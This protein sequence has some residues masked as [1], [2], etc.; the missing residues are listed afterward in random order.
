MR[1][2]LMSNNNLGFTGSAMYDCDFCHDSFHLLLPCPL[3]VILGLKARKAQD[4]AR[5]VAKEL[6]KDPAK[7]V[8]A[9][10]KECVDE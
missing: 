2:T 5:Q 1:Q 9:L 8:A 3:K 10:I 6:E 7:D 4:I